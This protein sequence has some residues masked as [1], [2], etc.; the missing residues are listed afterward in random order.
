MPIASSLRISP[1]EASFSWLLV[2]GFGNESVAEELRLALKRFPRGAG[3]THERDL[4][5]DKTGDMHNV[6]LTVVSLAD[7]EGMIAIDV[8]DVSLRKRS[9]TH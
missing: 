7:V 3:M 6:A 1:G 8:D 2:G 5:G 4:L 9:L